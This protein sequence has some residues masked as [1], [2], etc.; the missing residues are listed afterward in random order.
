MLPYLYVDPIRLPE[1]EIASLGEMINVVCSGL[2]QAIVTMKD[3]YEILS[4]FID[5]PAYF[6]CKSRWL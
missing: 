1:I 3:R 4:E 2:Q 5:H 6:Y